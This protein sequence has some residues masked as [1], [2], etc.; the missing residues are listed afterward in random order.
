MYIGIYDIYMSMLKTA[1]KNY[2]FYGSINSADAPTAHDICVS[3]CI[4]V[5]VIAT[6]AV[7]LD[8]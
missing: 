6:P 4:P 3:Y 5:K 2:F 7:F 8:T 1:D